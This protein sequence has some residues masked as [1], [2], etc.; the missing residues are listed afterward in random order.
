V[1]RNAEYE[2]FNAREVDDI[3][4]FVRDPFNSYGVSHETYGYHT[5][6]GVSTTYGGLG[7]GKGSAY[8]SYTTKDQEA[9]KP[10]GK[11]RKG[12]GPNYD[13]KPTQDVSLRR[14]FRKVAAQNSDLLREA[15]KDPNHAFHPTAINMKKEAA[16]RKNPKL[17]KKALKDPNHPLYKHA[18]TVKAQNGR[19]KATMRAALKDENHVLHGVAVANRNARLDKT[20]RKAQTKNPNLV[21]AALSN[22]NHPLHEA[23]HRVVQEADR[24]NNVAAFHSLPFAS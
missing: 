22:V 7:D 16:L 12:R 8:D 15:A 18:Q 20:I 19:H 6:Y 21:S 4:L 2:D 3:E 24:S 1:A 13:P 10:K 5:P 17:L 11:G 9:D 23:A 14:Q